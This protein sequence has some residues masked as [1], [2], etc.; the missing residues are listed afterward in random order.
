MKRGNLFLTLALVVLTT[1]SCKLPKEFLDGL[2]ANPAPL[3]YKNG[4]VE[5]TINGTFPEK[6]FTKKLTLTVTPVLTTSTGEVYKAEPKVFQG[7]KVTDNNETVTYK[8]GGSYTQTAKFAYVAGMEN[9]V[10]TMEAVVSSGNKEYALEAVEVARGVNTTPLLTSLEPAT[11]NLVALITPDKFQRIIKENTDAEI[12]YLIN[13]S[14]IRYSETKTEDIVALTNVIKDLKN[15]ENRELDGVTISS[16][17]SPDGAMDL[18]ERV[19]NNRGKNASSFIN[20][21]LKKIKADISIDSKLTAEDWEGFRRLVEE[22]SIEDKNLILRVLSMHKDP[23]QR[24]R[25][26]KNLSVAF[27]TIEENILPQLRRSQMTVT[28]NVIG[29]S[30]EEISELAK[31]D[32]AQLNVEE[33]LYAATLVNDTRAKIEIYRKA[34]ELYSDDYRSFNNLGVVLYEDDKV[35]E[36]ARA[37]GKAREINGNVAE[38]NYNNGLIALAENDLEKAEEF[39][40]NA[41]GVGEALNNANG[42]IAIM[43]GN[44]KKA[45]DLFGKSNSNNAAIANILNKNNGAAN[46]AL[47]NNKDANA[48]T[49][50]LKAIVAARTN[51]ESALISNLTE[52]INADV[53]LKTRAA[54]D[55]EFINFE[56]NE[57][58]QA[59][60]K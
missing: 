57:S 20:K 4:E 49:S 39:L 52:A 23:E 41:G 47:S 22:S 11:G 8:T 9:S 3:E 42:A 1:I 37:F 2:T 32:A 19:S 60:V 46:K 26:I 16:Y 31:T 54:N 40:G 28:V 5:F 43:K 29:K 56:E 51:D 55:V 44:Y 12:K 6:Y 14:N 48:T 59:L 10:L 33:L 13:Q 25:E 27:K 53:T 36:A 45:A 21:E 35:K 58:F 24:E 30:D 18:N 17:A 38:V 34:T 7:E 50:Y 15:A